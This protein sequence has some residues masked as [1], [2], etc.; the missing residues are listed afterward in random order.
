MPVPTSR[1][2]VPRPKHHCRSFW[3]LVVYLRRGRLKRLMNPS[4][5]EQTSRAKLL[6]QYLHWDPLAP[7]KA[8]TKSISP[9]VGLDDC[10]PLPCVEP[11]VA[12]DGFTCPGEGCQRSTV[13][14]PHQL[15][16][17]HVRAFKVQDEAR[18]DPRVSYESSLALKCGHRFCTPCWVS[19]LTTAI[20]SGEAGP[21]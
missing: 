14:W 20:Q 18:R 3:L 7:Q 11:M 1:R 13:G 12:N 16:G 9:S 17:Q 6:L 21:I 5:H 10:T 8:S 4:P 19:Y 2:D 15:K